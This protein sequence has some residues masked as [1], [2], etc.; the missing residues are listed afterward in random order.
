MK[1]DYGIICK[2]NRIEKGLTLNQIIANDRLNILSVECLN[3]MENLAEDMEEEKLE[4]L[5]SLL[6]LHFNMTMQ[7]KIDDKVEATFKNI[8]Q[9]RLHLKNYD[10]YFKE[11]A[12]MEDQIY[13]SLSY[14]KYLLLKLFRYAD[15]YKN[16]DDIHLLTTLLGTSLELLDDYRTALFYDS[17]GVIKDD[18][19]N[20]EIALKYFHQAKEYSGNID[21]ASLVSYHISLVLSKLGRLK[22]AFLYTKKAKLLFDEILSYKF[23]FNCS[24]QMAALNMQL[25]NDEPAAQQLLNCLYAAKVLNMQGVIY[26]Y[27]CW[28]Y[29]KTSKYN[30]LIETGD[31]L[32]KIEPSDYKSYFY[33][34][35]AHYK[36]KNNALA[37]REIAHA[38]KRLDD[39]DLFFKKLIQIFSAYLN[40]TSNNHIIENELLQLYQGIV[41]QQFDYPALFFILEVI[42]DFYHETC[43]I[44]EEN[45]YLRKLLMLSVK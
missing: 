13:C 21:V 9:C 31:K 7:T 22:E 8:M 28:I 5:F 27:L 37:K 36:L 12:D 2:M 3:K 23:S 44:D 15:Q 25:G 40:Q 1:N 16:D 19:G 32:S 26:N 41:H 6:G 18:E 35:W 43:Q 14:P 20:E 45:E 39:T 38:I 34:S 10:K 11:L 4:Y 24:L 17:L 30:D 29:I 33:K 42:T